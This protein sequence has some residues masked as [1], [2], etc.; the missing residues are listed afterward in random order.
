[1]TAEFPHIP[2]PSGATAHE[3]Q[4]PSFS[5]EDVWRDLEWSRH[6]AGDCVV[7]VQG[8]QYTDGRVD[9]YI[10]VHPPGVCEE[11]TAAGARQLAAALLDAADS[12]DMI[13]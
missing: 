9:R 3:W 8:S 11:L 10:A 1:M 7:V 2:V 5:L 6:D 4:Y 13:G 12:L